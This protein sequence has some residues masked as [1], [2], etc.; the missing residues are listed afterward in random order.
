MYMHGHQIPP[1]HELGGGGGAT[2]DYPWAQHVRIGDVLHTA[3]RRPATMIITKTVVVVVTQNKLA[4]M[5]P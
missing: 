2:Q 3:L 1:S 5:G 4:E